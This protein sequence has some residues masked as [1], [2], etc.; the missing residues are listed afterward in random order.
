[1]RIITARDLDAVM[2]FRDL[3]ETLRRAFRVGAVCPPVSSH[4]IYRPPELGHGTLQTSN[5]WHDFAEQGTVERGF[6]GTRV[7]TCLPSPSAPAPAIAGVYLLQSGKDGTPLALLDGRALT[8][9][10]TAATSALASS[11]LSR[12]DSARLLMIGAGPLAAYLIEAHASVRPVKEVL[13]WDRTPDAAEALSASLQGRGFSVSP[14]RDLGGAV[15]GADVVSNTLADQTPLLKE[16]WLPV[17]CYL[18]LVGATRP[19]QREVDDGVIRTA[20]IFVDRYD[21]ALSCAGDLVEP[22]EKG[23][24]TRQDIASDLHEL[25]QGDRAGRRFYEQVTLFKSVGTALADLAVAGH[26]FLR[27]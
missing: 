13:V 2:T 23:L 5:A 22:L 26:A 10:R 17:G 20:R 11:Y 1:M 8:L 16:E 24:L 3:L 19:D 15:R 9:W 7:E 12:E 27:V 6:I 25:C 4:T 14:T 21:D 18:D